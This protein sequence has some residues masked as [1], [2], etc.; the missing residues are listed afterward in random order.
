VFGVE[1]LP[2]DDPL[3]QPMPGRQVVFSGA[4]RRVPAQTIL[5]DFV[6]DR[7]FPVQPIGRARPVATLATGRPEGSW[8]VGARKTYRSGGQAVYL[9]FR[10]RD[11]QAAST[12]VETRVWFETLCALGAYPASGVFDEN[13]NPSV[14]SRTGDFLACA[15]PNGALA[16]CPHFKDYPENWP[17][18][19]FRD[20]EVDAR[21]MAENPPPDDFFELRDW[22]VAGQSVTYAG[23]HAVA[24]RRD[25][26]GAL[27]AFAGHDCV[28]I[29][30][31]GRNYRW[32]DAPVDIGWHPLA[33]EQG[34]ERY[35]P[36]YRVWCETPGPVRVPLALPTT[37]LEVW[38]GAHMPGGRSRRAAQGRAGY[39]DR[40]VAFRVEDGALALDI[41]DTLAGH[42][43]YVV[44]AV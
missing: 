21:I 3:G 28:G 10:P 38:L 9:G 36:L 37:G 31:D 42:W 8:C 35:R 26:S 44:Q 34:T 2:T 22:R 4:L 13:D 16:V 29:E 33:P 24:W 12:G 41:D 1:L 40:T 23:R 19:F 5:T 17:G 25:A 14:V 27:I 20:Q 43:L 11:D 39:G 30:I 7:V 18:G 6:V 15:F 32:S